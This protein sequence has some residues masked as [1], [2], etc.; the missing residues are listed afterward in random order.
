MIILQGIVPPLQKK[1][2]RTTAGNAELRRR[3]RTNLF[4][5]L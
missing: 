2:F 3:G 5:D 4:T 1:G